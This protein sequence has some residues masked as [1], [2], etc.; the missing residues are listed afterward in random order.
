MIAHNG[1]D[2]VFRLHAFQLV[3]KAVE[4]VCAVVHD[5]AGKDNQVGVYLVYSVSKSCRN[6][7]GINLVS[8]KM[9]VGKLGNAVSVET[10][11]NVFVADF[12]FFYDDVSEAVDNSA[13]YHE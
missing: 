9:K 12:H 6:I 2:A 3:F 1:V 8:S 7:F 4:F 5:V 13:D 10:L 11:G